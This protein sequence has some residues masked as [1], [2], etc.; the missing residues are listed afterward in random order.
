MTSKY[1][2]KQYV[3]TFQSGTRKDKSNPLPVGD[4]AVFSFDR[5]PPSTPPAPSS[6]QQSSSQVRKRKYIVE[7]DRDECD[8]EGFDGINILHA[9][10]DDE[11]ILV[12]N[13]ADTEV[14]K[15]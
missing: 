7:V 8:P 14:F 5:D 15:L 4:A 11:N 3:D 1:F 12:T 13:K 9:C 10:D 6:R 2:F